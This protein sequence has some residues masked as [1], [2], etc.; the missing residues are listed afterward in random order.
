ML[1]ITAPQQYSASLYATRFRDEMD[2][3]PG[4]I[5]SLYAPCRSHIR[6]RG[7]GAEP[8]L[9]GPIA[10][11]YAPVSQSVTSAIARR[12]TNEHPGPAAPGAAE[13]ITPWPR[14]PQNK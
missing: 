5:A 11:L 7:F 14:A 1:Q 6:N 3:L 13:Q 10:S 8:P 9:P 12:Q 2:T 4:P